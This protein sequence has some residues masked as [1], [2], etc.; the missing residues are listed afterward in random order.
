MSSPLLKKISGQLKDPQGISLAQVPFGVTIEFT[1]LLHGASPGGWIGSAAVSAA[2]AGFELF[3]AYNLGVEEILS[4]RLL[5]GNRIIQAG[6]TAVNDYQTAITVTNDAYEDMS[7]TDDT[8]YAVIKGNVSLGEDNTV[9]VPLDAG[10]L[11]VTIN[12]LVFRNTEQ[13]AQGKID[14]YGN[15]EIKIARRLLQQPALSGIDCNA[16]QPLSSLFVSLYAGETLITRSA[17]TQPE[18]CCTTVDLNIADPV[19]YSFFRNEL[20][21]LLGILSSAA[22]LAQASLH[23]VITEGEDSELPSLSE[24]SHLDE[25]I[26]FNLVSA[27]KVSQSSGMVLSHAY[28]FTRSNG[29]N[30]RVW[31]ELEPAVVTQIINDYRSTHIIPA[32]GSI[33]DTL[34]LLAGYK[35]ELILDDTSEDGDDMGVILGAIM[36]PETLSTFMEISLQQQGQPVAS[37]WNQVETVLGSVTRLHIQRG[38]QTLAVT[39]MQPE[40]TNAIINQETALKD[41]AVQWTAAE[42]LDVVEATCLQHGKLCIPVSVQK[43]ALGNE[44]LMKEIYASRLHELTGDIFA[45]AVMGEKIAAGEIAGTAADTDTADFIRANPDFDLRF[46]N[47]WNYN[48]ADEG[49]S[50]TVRKDLLPVQNIMRVTGGKPEATAALLNAGMKSSSDIVELSEDGFVQ[51]FSV[52]IPVLS[53]IAA[54][55]VYAAAVHSS[56]AVAQLKTTIQPNNFQ[57]SVLPSALWQQWLQNPGPSTNPDLQT[58]FGSMDLCSCSECMSMYSPA[59]Y[60]TDMMNVLLNKLET[61]V[62][63]AYDELTR[64]R[65]DLVHIDLTCKNTNTAIPY[66]DLVN[67]LLELVVLRDMSLQPGT[68][69]TNMFVPKSFQTSGSAKDLEAYPEH[70]YK[71]GNGDYKAYEAYSLV[72]DK[73]LN[74]A[75]YPNTLPFNLALNEGRTYFK[76]LGYKRYDLMDRFKPVT[77]YFDFLTEPEINEYNAMAEW[78]GISRKEADIIT[79]H[80]AP[81]PGVE[82]LHYDLSSGN[83]LTQLTKGAPGKGMHTLLQKSNITYKELLQLLDTD[84]LNKKVGNIAPLKLESANPANPNTCQLNELKL[85][86]NI[87]GAD[88]AAFKKWYRFLRLQRATGW[89]IYQLDMVLT[90]LNITALNAAEF[91]QVAKVHQFASRFGIAPER[92]SGFWNKISTKNYVNADSDNAATLPSVYDSLFRNK[93]LINPPEAA[94]NLPGSITGTYQERSGTLVAAFNIKEEELFQLL[95]FLG[96]NVD[97]TVPPAVTLDALSRV[98]GLINMANGTGISIADLLVIMKLSETDGS[99]FLTASP[100][101]LAAAMV[102]LA[103][104]IDTCKGLLFSLAETEYLVADKDVKGVF[105]PSDDTIQLFYESLRSELKK[106]ISNDVLTV[107]N[108]SDLYN[109]LSNVV[110]RYFSNQFNMDNDTAQYL[111]TE[112]IKISSNTISLLDALVLPAFINAADPASPDPLAPL[113]LPII[114]A[115]GI[116]DYSFAE[117]FTAFRRVGKTTFITNRYK[118]SRPEL[119]FLT[120]NSA[121]FEVLDITTLPVGSSLMSNDNLYKLSFLND[122]IKVKGTLNLKTEEFLEILE[123]SLGDATKTAWS[124]KVAEITSWPEEDLLFLTGTNN[125]LNKGVLKTTYEPYIGFGYSNDFRRGSLLLQ[126]SRIIEATTRIGLTAAVTYNA[127]KT[128]LEMTDSGNIRKAAKAKHKEEEWL[129]IAKPLQDTLREKQRQALVDYVV[130]RP[131]ITGESPNSNLFWENENDLFAYLLIDVEMQPCMKTSRIKQAIST[132]QLFM[133]RLILNLE[134]TDGDP[135]THITITPDMTEQWKEWRKWYRIWEANRKVFLYPEN[136]IEPELR[137]DK[138]P[139]FKELETQLLQDEVKDNTAEDAFRSYLELVD[140]VGRLEPVSAY[141]E[142]ENSGSRVVVDRTHVFGK[143]SSLPHKYYY[144]RLED[145]EWSPWEKVNA[146]IKSDHVVPV[147]WNRKLY[148]FWLTF[149]KKKRTEEEIPKPVSGVVD[150]WVDN[151]RHSGLMGTQQGRFENSY[152]DLSNDS[153]NIWNITLNWSQFKDGKWLATE[154]S[155]D[156]MNMDMLKARISTQ[157]KTSLTNVALT[158]KILGWLNNR[159][160]I[161]IDDF[162]RNRLY[163]YATPEGLTPD[164]ESG[165]NFSIMFTPGL[166]EVATGVHTFLWRGDNSQDPYVGRVNYERGYQLIAPEG[167]RINKMKF[168]EDPYGDGKLKRDDTYYKFVTSNLNPSNSYYSYDTDQVMVFPSIVRGNKSTILNTTANNGGYKLTARG[169]INGNEHSHYHNPLKSE[170]LF[171]DEKNTFFVRWEPTGKLQVQKSVATLNQISIGSVNSYKQATYTLPALAVVSNN[172]MPA[173]AFAGNALVQAYQPEAYK[174]H[175]FYHAQIK[176]FVKALNKD[177]IKGLLRIENQKQNNTLNFAGNYAPTSLVH[178]DY[179]KNNVQFGFSDAYSI[180]NWEIFF[181]APMMIAQRLSDNQQFDEA[182][183][184]YHYVFNPTSNTDISLAYTGGIKRFWKFYPFYNESQQPVE[185]LYD[186]LLAINA[187]NA[188]AVA[189]VTKWEKNPFKPHVIARMRILAYMK[190]VLMKYIDNLVAWG[191]QLFRRDTIESINEATQLY[192]LAANLLGERPQEIPARIQPEAMTFDELSDFG[193]DAL[194]NSMVNIESYFTPNPNQPVTGGTKGTPIY[195]KMFY[196]CLPKND[197]LMGYWDTVADRL[198]KIRNCMNIDGSVRQLPLFEP[199]VDPALLVRATAMGVDINSILDSVSA[200]SLPQYRFSYMLQKANEFCNEVRGLG[201][202]LLSTLEKKDAEQLSLLRSG[203]E[204]QLLEKVKFIKEQQVTEAE[205]ALEAMRLSKENTQLRFSYYSSR[206]FTNANEQKH[207]QSI[208]SGLVLQAV[209][210]AMQTVASGLSIIPQFHGQAFSA[211]GPSF[212]GQQLAAAM[213]AM[214]MNVGVM[215]SINNAKGSMAATL[216]GYERRKD[217]W[218]FQADTAEKELEQLDKQIL[219]AEIRL[220]IAKRELGN[221]ELQMENSAETDAYMRSKFT[222]TE[223]YTWMSNQVAATYFQS[224]QL[225]YDLAKKAEQ[226]YTAELPVAQQPAGGFIKFGYWD[227]LRK[228]LMSGEKLQF[229]LRKMETT[230]MEENKREFELTKNFSLALINPEALL[231]LRK[232]GT[233]TFNLDEIWYDLDFPAHYM[234]KIKSVSLSIPCIAGPYTTIASKLSLTQSFLQKD[235]LV[236]ALEVNKVATK[237]IAT[238]TGQNDAGMFELNFRDERY[239]PFENA[240]A[241][242]IWQ[243][244]MMA[245]KGLRQFNYE[246]ISDVLVQVRYTARESE[247]KTAATVNRL[248]QQLSNLGNGAITLPRYFSLKHEFSNEWYKGFNIVN[249]M[250]SGEE[251]SRPISVSLQRDQFPAYATGKKIRVESIEFFLNP[252]KAGDEYRIEFGNQILTF[253]YNDYKAEVSV[254]VSELDFD[255]NDVSKI[256]D[257]QLYKMDGTTP[258]LLDEAELKDVFFIVHYKLG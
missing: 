156:V 185:T 158:K 190:N 33:A 12:K 159:E 170:F 240:G 18:D 67:E 82:W 144:R 186:L 100:G 35:D 73:R 112:K 69:Y 220:D 204:L 113:P 38:M 93:A 41:I 26:L 85:T 120:V 202:S 248:Q 129:K 25:S 168:V 107:V 201:S 65:E 258:L 118:L 193:F 154:M 146:D 165:I 98:Y 167:T 188:E 42:W 172:T 48:L 60:F 97:A 217:D 62:P 101:Q 153:A 210:G 187:G 29:I 68:P 99:I 221:H 132:V 3:T 149:Q 237:A 223:L 22:G 176:D 226:C 30:I 183:K 4:Y 157:A 192:I 140:E 256:M 53:A 36:D 23:T 216:G 244:D 229:D 241:I 142:L 181:H 117:L 136:W 40:L 2:N 182:Q 5:S 88:A 215:A 56:L 203:Q 63:K 45:T 231:A 110:L 222:N 119:E 44:V 137:D 197:K 151:I 95:Q 257:I 243:L 174:F 214:S 28:A 21:Y 9:A 114:P 86:V 232:D 126:L 80:N 103:E 139:F 92:L 152:N 76:H 134:N 194:S 175:T 55:Q 171:E 245:D 209:Q 225:A 17:D 160:E 19:Y 121:A 64:R 166:D 250:S 59:A 255:E 32:G 74:E 234:R 51:K 61:P 242:S 116:A 77:E 16:A 87:A 148:L 108:P 96:I 52:Q 37:L 78:L 251:V 141:H 58:L 115:N 145:N 206:P 254:G 138:T 11:T 49:Y 200:A 34:A 43:E 90:S 102:A 6:S 143:T 155:K 104:L 105:N 13:L 128:D 178:S 83:W 198:F 195:G 81:L 235:P 219:S 75:I 94:F 205:Q 179:P 124:E 125:M 164:P 24:V 180:Y 224:Y 239:I 84:F 169:S 238:S 163:L 127:L 233:C 27:A 71:D 184:W 213:N 91:V 173:I 46:N 252:S 228:G 70:T 207:L 227:S 236:S 15:Y 57:T 211:V 161:K 31:A 111:L 1:T 131:T 122:W 246:T 189:Q 47:I 123:I 130:A 109:T 218:T 133:D 79:N 191:D 72:Y 10:Q 199:P 249:N 89:S 162:F 230:Y 66:I 54:Q 253:S 14:A 39:G 135:N 177:G 208:Q 247:T 106:L 7:G 147:I 150:K 212:G 8:G 196:F 20:D 50:E